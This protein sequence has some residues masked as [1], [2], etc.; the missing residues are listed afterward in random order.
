MEID[1]DNMYSKILIKLSTISLIKNIE[2]T[3]LNHSSRKQLL[4]TIKKLKQQAQMDIDFIIEQGEIP[5]N[6]DIPIEQ[7]FK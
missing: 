6:N 2:E 3:H 7:I 5:E 1:Y 4:V